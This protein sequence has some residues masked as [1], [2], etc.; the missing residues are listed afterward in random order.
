MR[1]LTLIVGIV[2][3]VTAA[4]ELKV[5]VYE[6]PTEC[7]ETSKVKVGDLVGI[8]YTGFIDESSARGE[9]GSQFDSS[10]NRD[11]LE[12]TIGVGDVIQGWDEGLIGLCEGAKARLVVPPEMGYGSRGAGDVIPGGAT[13]RF[14]VEVVSV[15]APQW[16]G[17]NLF[18][19][20]DVDEDGVLTPEE[21]LVHFRRQ[22][23]NAELPPG[24][25]E[26]DDKNEDG[27][28][29]REEWGGPRMD[30]PS[31]LEMLYRNA[32][33]TALGLAVRWLCQ[34]DRERPTPEGKDEL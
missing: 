26:K 10:R 22:D 5:D 20:L 21:I 1:G 25:M 24:L 15:K 28:V 2:A 30:W 7:D 17:P 14:D 4:E 19:E 29:S 8:H 27:V 18:E 31:C 11:V 32:E 9:L 23:P 33:P 13:L 34:R 3:A 12:R 6:G 16:V